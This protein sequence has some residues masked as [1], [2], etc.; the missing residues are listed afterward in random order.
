VVTSSEQREQF[1]RDGYLV[2]DPEV[3]TI[4]LD[5]ILT[6]LKDKYEGDEPIDVPQRNA[7]RIQD[8][9]RISSNVKA[10]ARAPKVLTMLEELYERK[11]LPFQTLN[12]PI[13]TQQRPHQDTIHF[14]SKPPGYMCGIWVALEDIDMNNGPLVYYPGSH[15][16]PEFTPKDV[17]VRASFED[18]PRYEQFIDDMLS[19]SS[20]EPH[21]GTIK[22]GQ[23]LLWAANLVHGGAPQKDTSRS[24][25]SQVTHY[26]FEHCEYYTPM[27]SDETQISRR[28]PTWIV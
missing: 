27:L 14:N 17:G 7:G 24:R 23:A 15:K 21:Y 28:N 5:R 25:H 26:F 18:Y 22:K 16:W 13:G 4:I 19:R 10:L 2:F 6:D 11:P 9:W 20:L 12:F 1:E 8:A 3:P